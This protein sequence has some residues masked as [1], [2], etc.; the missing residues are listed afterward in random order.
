MSTPSDGLHGV[1]EVGHG[2]GVE[3][4]GKLGV[5]LGLVNV[6]VGGAVDYVLDV[7]VAT[8]FRQPRRR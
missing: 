5:V 1:G 4:F 8:I 2:A 3:Q 6:G 7:V